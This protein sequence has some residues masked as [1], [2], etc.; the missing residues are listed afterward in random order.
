MEMTIVYL[1]DW[2]DFVD[3]VKDLAELYYSGVHY[4][5]LALLAEKKYRQHTCQNY[6]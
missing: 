4:L 6:F 2:K 1:L 3:N 5:F